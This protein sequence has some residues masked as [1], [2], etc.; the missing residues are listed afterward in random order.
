M[1]IKKIECRS[2][3]AYLTVFIIRKPQCICQSASISL[4][5]VTC[6]NGIQYRSIGQGG[7]IDFYVQ[8]RSR[9]LWLAVGIALQN[10]GIQMYY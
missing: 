5:E 10:I 1:A 9:I 6:L 2:F 3:L 8:Y 7:L 4:V